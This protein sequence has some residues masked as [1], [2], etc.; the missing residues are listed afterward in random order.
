[1]SAN[2]G[3]IAQLNGSLF[4]TGTRAKGSSSTA[5]LS[6]AYPDSPLDPGMTEVP[7]A[8]NTPGTSLKAWYQAN[9]LEGVQTKNTLTGDVD[10]NYG[11]LGSHLA[12]A[13]DVTAITTDVNGD[14]VDPYVPDVSAGNVVGGTYPETGHSG[15]LGSVSSPHAAVQSSFDLENI[16][17]PGTS[18]VPPVV[19]TT[20]E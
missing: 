2:Q 12:G 18:P 5:N 4:G 3:T 17:S 19:P 14:P 11:D 16:T 20:T 13:P 8:T 15:L 9:V 6:A 1:M 10:M 7:D